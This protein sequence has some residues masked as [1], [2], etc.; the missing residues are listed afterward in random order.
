MSV[1][2]GISVVLILAG[3]LAASAQAFTVTSPAVSGPSETGYDSGLVSAGRMDAQYAAKPGAP[4]NSPSFPISWSNVP[5]GTKVLA[6][7]LDDPDARPLLASRGIKLPAFL[8]WTVTDIDP[9]RGGLPANASVDMTSLVQG[10]NG[11]GRSGYQAPQPPAD[12]P[13]NTGKRL[14]HIYRLALY[15]LS[16]PTGLPSGYSLEDLR[17]AIKDKVLG[18]A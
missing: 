11:A 18:E 15:A 4:G 16:S 3:A 5:P 7:I 6:L 17:K 14:I 12:V 1:R 9:S 2:T 8:H 13:K 10:K